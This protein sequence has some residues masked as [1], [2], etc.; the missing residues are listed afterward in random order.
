MVIGQADTPELVGEKRVTHLPAAALAEGK[1]PCQLDAL[2]IDDQTDGDGLF[3][4]DFLEYPGA[5]RVLEPVADAQSGV[6]VAE[7]VRAGRAN[8]VPEPE[9]AG[10]WRVAGKDFLQEVLLGR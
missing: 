3:L 4:A 5:A 10:R 6:G 9:Y 2:R 7:D 8:A 1:D